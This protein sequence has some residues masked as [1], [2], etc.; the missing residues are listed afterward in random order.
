MKIICE[1]CGCFIDRDKTIKG[2][3]VEDYKNIYGTYCHECGA[4]NNPTIEAVDMIDRRD[5][6]DLL[7]EQV[8]DKLRNKIRR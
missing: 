8:R 2:Q 1:K 3:V 7:R 5:R 6:L 4:F